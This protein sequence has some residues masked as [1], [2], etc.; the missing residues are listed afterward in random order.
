MIV[1]SSMFPL[2]I[3]VMCCDFVVWSKRTDELLKDY[4][5]MRLC[6][7]DVQSD[8]LLINPKTK[9]PYTPK[10]IQRW[11]K[12]L[13]QMAILNKNITPHSFRHGKAHYILDQGG[14]VRDVAVMLRHVNPQ[15]SFN[16]LQ[17]SPTRYLETA[18]KYLTTA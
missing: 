16:Y 5:A 10:T 15:S 14:S 11:I 18:G 17:L 6:L 12:E 8:K 4:L 1:L 3:L 13:S 9:K 7:E 2:M